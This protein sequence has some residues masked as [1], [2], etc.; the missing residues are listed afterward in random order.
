MRFNEERETLINLE[1][2]GGAY[3]KNGI[4]YIDI[5]TIKTISFK[6]Y[7]SEVYRAS[8]VKISKQEDF[9][10]VTGLCEWISCTVPVLS[11]GWDW[12]NSANGLVVDGELYTNFIVIGEKGRSLSEDSQYYLLMKLIRKF[13]WEKKLTFNSHSTYSKIIH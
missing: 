8:E 12:K 11:I 13:E 2:E 4:L 10:E 3:R 1:E 6:Q 5:E 7:F 9:D